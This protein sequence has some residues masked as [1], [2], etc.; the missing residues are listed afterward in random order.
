MISGLQRHNQQK[1][2]SVGALAGCQRGCSDTRP[3]P[4][5]RQAALDPS[6][7]YLF[8]K[9]GIYEMPHPYKVC[10]AKGPRSGLKLAATV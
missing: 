5:A 10:I 7:E 8:T 1:A 3:L 4:P 2:L 9:W 6:K